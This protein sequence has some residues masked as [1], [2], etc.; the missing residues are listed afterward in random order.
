MPS[1]VVKVGAASLGAVAVLALLKYRS[2]QSVKV[3]PEPTARPQ[4]AVQQASPEDVALQAAKAAGLTGLAAQKA[5]A[6]EVAGKPPG[7]PD[8]SLSL[9]EDIRRRLT[10]KYAPLYLDIE[11][12]GNSCGASKVAIVMVS[13]AFSNKTRINRQREVQALLR[14]DLDSGRLHAL[15]LRLNTPE[16]YQKLL[17]NQGK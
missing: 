10:A 8:N 4:A 5:A 17:Q 2:Q 11:D 15:S 6:L 7:G 13:A 1:W 16:E 3:A 14:E 12:Q 9:E